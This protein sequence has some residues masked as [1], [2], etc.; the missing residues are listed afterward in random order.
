MS[1]PQRNLLL[2]LVL[3]LAAGFAGV[4]WWLIQTPAP[5]APIAPPVATPGPTPAQPE[6]PVD[7]GQRK[8]PLEAAVAEAVAETTVVFP[9]KVELELLA[10]A[11]RPKGEGVQAM[12]S[13]AAARFA[14]SVHGATGEP[15]AAEI[16]FVAGANAGRRLLTDR[17]GRFGANDLYPG[18]SV[19]RISATGTPGSLREVLLRKGSDTQLNVGYG[20][21]ALVQGAVKD[22]VGVPI[23]DA[24]VTIDGQEGRSDEKGEFAVAGVASGD[25]FVVVEKSGYAAH[26]ER[27]NVAGAQMFE[28]GRLVYVLRPAARLEVT[29]ED[30]LNA[31]TEAWL[32]VLP[33]ALDGERDFPWYRLNP[34]RI[35]PGGTKVI[36]DL[37]AKTV[38]LRLF[39]AGA[40]AKPPMQSV[41]LH[42]KETGRA[43]LHL[44][45]A[46][47][48]N[49]V[50]TQDGQPAS[51]A[52]VVLEAP[53]H[54]DAMLSVLGQSNYLD[55]ERE[56]LPDFP[57][58]V[59][60]T[61]ATP[62]GEY[63]LTANEG[64]SRERYIHGPGNSCAAARRGSIS[65][66]SART[67]TPS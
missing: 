16:L 34:V 15:L 14:G 1:G 48:V 41:T 13:D 49:G 29:I 6:P 2:V 10:S 65:P 60:R 30:R 31:D 51:G 20:R 39:H 19:V 22:S 64:V 38:M 37:P 21:L 11:L 67:E 52:E 23:A 35:F 53:T 55:L 4:A 42:E 46:A 59:Q 61:K 33:Q 44:A 18:L 45:P 66:S 36:E 12:G 54:S 32:Y 5:A 9:L 47:V 58:A 56:V 63:V 62:G 43:A 25:T 28:K 3:A 17:E 7:D 8:V 57:A 27:L 24:K 40:T 26:M 50:V